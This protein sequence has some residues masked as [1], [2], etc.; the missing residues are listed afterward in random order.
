MVPTCS[1]LEL[2]GEEVLLLPVAMQAE[3]MYCIAGNFRG[4]IFSQILRIGGLSR[5]LSIVGVVIRLSAIR[6]KITREMLL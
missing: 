1:T 2:A 5:K 4:R 3:Y 6:E